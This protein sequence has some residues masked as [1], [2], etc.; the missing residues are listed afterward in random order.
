MHSMSWLCHWLSWWGL[1]SW[2]RQWF[3][4]FFLPHQKQ[5]HTKRSQSYLFQKAC[6]SLQEC[7]RWGHYRS[8]RL[9]WGRII[10]VQWG[11]SECW[12]QLPCWV[13]IQRPYGFGRRFWRGFCYRG[14]FFR[15]WICLRRFFFLTFF[16]QY[17][18]QVNLYIALYFY[19]WRLFE[20]CHSFLN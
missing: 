10:W 12:C 15:L 7:K 16:F 11:K 9:E 6:Y 19:N 20:K 5:L 8:S 4:Y 14:R 3:R 2:Q 18:T 1:Q 17:L 13:C